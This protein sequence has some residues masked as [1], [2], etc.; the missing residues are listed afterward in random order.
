VISPLHTVEEVLHLIED[1]ALFLQAFGDCVAVNDEVAPD[2]RAFAG[3][4]GA[5]GEIALWSRAI[6]D[7]LDVKALGAELGS[8]R[9]R[10]R[11]R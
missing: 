5:A 3:L 4:A 8:G 10:S 1:R 9:K 7:A 2:A 6:F 11:R